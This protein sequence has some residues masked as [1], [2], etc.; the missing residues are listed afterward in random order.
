MAKNPV[1]QHLLDHFEFY[2]FRTGPSEPVEVKLRGQFDRRAIPAR[3][4]GRR[5]FAPVTDKNG[6][7]IR[8]KDAHL[9][10]YVI[11][12]AG[13]EPY[14][15]VRVSNQFGEQK[16]RLGPARG[17][18]VPAQKRGH[19]RPGRLDHFKVYP[20]VFGDFE[21]R[22]VRLRNQ[23]EDGHHTVEV[24]RPAAFAV[25]VGKSG[26]GHRSR[27][28]NR[29]AHLMIYWISPHSFQGSTS[30]RDQF[31]EYKMRLLRSVF[32]A[33]PTKKIDWGN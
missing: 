21:P 12:S 30:A 18:L 7:G 2:V 9:T 16:Y 6:E 33:V 1:F 24:E 8:D 17:L 10:W 31:G 19:D 27:I 5:Y 26:E 14:R 29:E 13:R 4:Y 11:E 22:R 20:V 28:V 32:L 3:V 25:P 23:F 15:T